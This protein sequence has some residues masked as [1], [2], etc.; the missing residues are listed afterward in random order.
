MS[1]NKIKERIKSLK[2]SL[3]YSSSKPII[4]GGH[5]FKYDDNSFN[6]EGQLREIEELEAQLYNK[7]K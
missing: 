6:N 7:K 5:I 4:H 2:E 1:E 3:R